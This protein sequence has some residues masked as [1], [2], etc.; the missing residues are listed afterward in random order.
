MI[1]VEVVLYVIEQATPWWSLRFASLDGIIIARGK[2]WVTA[3]ER[4][5]VKLLYFPIFYFA[6][7]DVAHWS[8]NEQEGY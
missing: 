8:I 2:V 4:L 7:K 6:H 5:V 3:L 1:V